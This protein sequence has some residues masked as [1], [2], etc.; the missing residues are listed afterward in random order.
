MAKTQKFSEDILLE[1]VIKYSESYKGKIK[2]TKL[3]EW[4]KGNIE[5]LEEVKDYNFTRPIREK[6]VKTGKV[7]ERQK[8]CTIRI[9]D[10]NKTRNINTMV[11]TNVL[12]RSS[13]IDAFF[14]LSLSVQR[15]LVVE[16]R[17]TV[18]TLLAKNSKY[19]RENDTFRSINKEQELQIQ[20]INNLIN[21][22]QKKHTILEKQ[23][24][25]LIRNV[26]EN[27]RRR[28]LAE[29]GIRDGSIDI[30]DYKKC[31][32]KDMS[33]MF[34]I[35]NNLMKYREF[36]DESEK[37]GVNVAEEILKGLKFE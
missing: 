17:E 30:N 27:E 4:C 5:G 18:D 20:S 22:V 14:E 19:K 33:E 6:N 32:E 9:N 35:Y 10:I 21:S 31:I 36:E 23:V 13:N 15:K 24:R 2:T 25:Y 1:A 8:S 11:N 7:R 28:M 16:T 3:A 26:D 37:N 29:M 12:L 34:N